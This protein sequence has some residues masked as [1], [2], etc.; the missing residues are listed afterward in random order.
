MNETFDHTILLLFKT[1]K[2]DRPL[3]QIRDPHRQSLET[4]TRAHHFWPSNY[5]AP[6]RDS[7]GIHAQPYTKGLSDLFVPGKSIR[8][9]STQNDQSFKDQR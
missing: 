8:S 2:I 1:L 3:F 4:T 7:A 5:D 9:S 6:V